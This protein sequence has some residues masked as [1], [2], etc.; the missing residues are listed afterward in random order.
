MRRNRISSFLLILILLFFLVACGSSSDSSEQSEMMMQSTEDS[1]WDGADEADDSAGNELSLELGD[2]IIENAN[3]YYE[4]THFENALEF[5]NEQVTAFDGMVE[6]SVREQMGSSYQSYGEYISMTI[7]IPNEQ[8][9]TFIETLNDFDQLYIQSQ[10]VGQSDVTKTYRDNETRIAVLREEE[11][12]LRE[13]L[14]EQGSL[15]EI[16]QIRTRLS[17]IIMEREIFE[18]EN[19]NFDE[20]I[21]FSTVYLSIQQTDRASNQDV[22]GFWDRMTNAFGDSFFSFIS[23]MQQLAINL[24]YFFP[25]L[26]IGLIVLGIAYFVWKKFHQK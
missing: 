5:V 7:R 20:Q 22:S 1:G 23:V 11:E 16:L 25:Y 13:M 18:A 9:Y 19:Q 12:T 17:E 8:L 21:E 26:I 15:E 14:Q 6:H 4:T 2:K 24:V 3:L 10:E